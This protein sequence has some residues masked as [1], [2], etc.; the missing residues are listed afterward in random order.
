MG[1]YD[2][3]GTLMALKIR[4]GSEGRGPESDLKTELKG[5]DNDEY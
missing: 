3:S 1:R 4:Q 5:R 2:V